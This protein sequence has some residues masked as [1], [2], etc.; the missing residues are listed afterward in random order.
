MITRITGTLSRI[1]EDE[2]RIQVGP[3]EYQVLL[4]ESVR[5]Q[6][7]L[8]S[9]AE[10]TFH[11]TEYLEGNPAGNRFI[12]R[13]IGFLNEVDLEF[14]ELFCTVEKIG[15][16]KALKAMARPVREIADAIQRQDTKWL[17]T[18]PGIGAATAEQ[19]VTT[20]KRKITK[21]L[22]AA[23][24]LAVAESADFPQIPEALAAGSGK[25]GSRKKPPPEPISLP[26]S[27]DSSLIDDLYQALLALGHTPIEA[28]TRLDTLLSSGKRFS[29]LDEALTLI[30][31]NK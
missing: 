26:P 12:P 14:F 1:L 22:V 2:A 30:Y 28:R 31:A 18:L 23:P 29:T 11:I 7:Q 8:R 5:R 15:A 3:F 6:L 25:A 21:F 9:G 17:S 16:K 24:P 10:V 19:I 4:P 27:P 20:L 13:R